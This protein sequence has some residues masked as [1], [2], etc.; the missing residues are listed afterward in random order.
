M[1]RDWHIYAFWQHVMER[2]S[3]TPDG[4]PWTCEKNKGLGQNYKPD[5]CPRTL[6]LIGRAVFVQVGQWWT[7]NDCNK[8]AAGIN[9]VLGAYFEP[10]SDRVGWYA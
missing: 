4:C 7:E 6:D 1:A 3:A 2:K 5:M 10:A 8:V 9:K